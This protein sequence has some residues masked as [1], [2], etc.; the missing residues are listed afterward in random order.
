MIDLMETKK[1]ESLT[2]LIEDII[3]VYV[4]GPFRGRTQWEIMQ[5]VRKAEEASL[6]LWKNGFVAIC[7]HTMTQHFQDECPDETWLNGCIEILKRCDAIYLVEGWE[8]SEGTLEE[9][10]VAEELNL[11]IMGK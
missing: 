6:M 4:A 2:R 3:I 11:T 7:P 5:N 1:A 10:R 9:L 8:K